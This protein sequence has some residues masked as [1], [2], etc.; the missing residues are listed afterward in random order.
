MSANC[1]AVGL[2]WRISVSWAI[3][4]K[5]KF[6]TSPLTGK[7]LKRHRTDW[8]QWG[9]RHGLGGY[10]QLSL[11]PHRETY[12]SIIRRWFVRN[13]Q[14]LQSKSV[15]N[16]CKVLRLLGDD[17][18]PPD[19]LPG[20]CPWIP[21]G[22][23]RPPDLLGYRPLP[24]WKSLSLR[25]TGRINDRTAWNNNTF[26]AYDWQWPHKN[27]RFENLTVKIKGICYVLKRMH[28]YGNEYS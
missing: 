27:K 8:I 17:R 15:N 28:Q 4:P 19:P 7:R 18:S 12:W 10:P 13:F 6:L 16:V 1:F 20:L 14:L 9:A 26:V 5:W 23:F 11:S 22:D 21:L 2:H 3:P 24:E 25:L